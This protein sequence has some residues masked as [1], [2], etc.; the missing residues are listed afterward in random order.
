MGSDMGSGL[1]TV[2]EYGNGPEAHINKML[3][4]TNGVR[5]MV[6]GE[7]IMNVVLPLTGL[8]S[9]QLQVCPED[10][11]RA[12]EILESAAAEGDI[13]EGGQ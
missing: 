12:I 6:L 7:D 2:G 9:V 4:E 10:A 1:V 3:L 8:L 13:M 5:A 11:E